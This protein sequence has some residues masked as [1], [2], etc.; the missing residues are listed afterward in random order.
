MWLG[1]LGEGGS[2]GDEDGWTGF[3]FRGEVAALLVFWFKDREY[4]DAKQY[5]ID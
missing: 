3:G 1:F 4:P 5:T 2:E